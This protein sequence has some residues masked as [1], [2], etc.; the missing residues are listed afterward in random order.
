MTLIEEHPTPTASPAASAPDWT[1]RARQV[2]ASLQADVAERD[3]T[4]EISPAVFDQLRAAGLTHALVPLELSGGGASFTE[5]AGILRTLATYDAST[6]VTLS[7]HSHL[8][9]AQVWRHQHGI[10]ATKVF[11]AV[12]GGAMLVSTGASDWVSSNGTATK[13]E[14]GFVVSARKTPASG[15]EVGQLFATSIRWDFAPDGPSV[16][17]C[18][19]PRSADGVSL[20]LTWNTMGLRATGS[21]TVVFDEV[22]VPDAAVALIRPA[23]VWHPVWNTVMGCA[24]PL[25]MSAYLG[26]ADAALELARAAAKPANAALMGEVVNAHTAATDLIAAMVR[27]ADELH[28]DNTDEHA[29]HTL[30]RKTVATT[31]LMETV[32]LAVELVGG[33]SYSRGSELERMWRDVQGAQFHPLPRSRQLPFTGR[34]A[35]GMSPI[36][37]PAPVL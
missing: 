8:L 34:V 5:L 1:E 33:S 19:I 35:M 36:A 9:A 28:F 17:H 18:T 7:M 27:D 20:E 13:V 29:S 24:M 22:F 4:G 32:R 3:R 30:A 21:H 2:G 11:G 14:G 37:T 12:A 26:V 25:I 6:A 15:C 10:D 16:I 23:D 31:M